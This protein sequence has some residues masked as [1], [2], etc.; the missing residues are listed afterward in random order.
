MCK[1]SFEKEIIALLENDERKK[2]DKKRNNKSVFFQR[3]P[4]TG[5]RVY[6]SKRQQQYRSRRTAVPSQPAHDQATT[7][8]SARNV[9]NDNDTGL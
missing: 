7:T 6:F 8:C 3:C 9:D 5:Q 4:T 2:K 1:Y